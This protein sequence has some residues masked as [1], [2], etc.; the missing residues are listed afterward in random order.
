MCSPPWATIDVFLP[1]VAAHSG[2]LRVSADCSYAN[3]CSTAIHCCVNE[4]V[5]L[6]SWYFFTKSPD[7]SE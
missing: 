3:Y 2:K 1:I 6:A 4:F 5:S 7:L